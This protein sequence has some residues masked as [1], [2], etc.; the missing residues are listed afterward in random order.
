MFQFSRQVQL[1]VAYLTLY[2]WN[3]SASAQDDLVCWMMALCSTQCRDR[4][5]GSGIEGVVLMQRGRYR[6]WG[7]KRREGGGDQD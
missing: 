4:A 6:D 3:K 2:T 7:E 5:E 1:I